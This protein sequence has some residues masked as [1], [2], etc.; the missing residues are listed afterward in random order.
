MQGAPS[1][2]D[3]LTDGEMS[4]KEGTEGPQ[5]S[6]CKDSKGRCGEHGGLKEVPGLRV[7]CLREERGGLGTAGIIRGYKRPCCG[8]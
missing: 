5:H 3:A 6:V 1:A 8:G 7:A 4:G 2:G